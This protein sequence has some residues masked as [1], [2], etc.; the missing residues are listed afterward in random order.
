MKNRMFASRLRWISANLL[1]GG[2]LAFVAI[3]LGQCRNTES[4][5]TGVSVEKADFEPGPI[6]G[7][8]L[9]RA[10]RCARQLR[11]C[12]DAAEERR[13]RALEQCQTDEC[14]RRIQH[15]FMQRLAECRKQFRACLRGGG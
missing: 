14:R 13:K 4:T 10:E 11:H 2:L 3:G 6:E 12:R 15:A 5:V 1:V 9:G 8:D 7:R